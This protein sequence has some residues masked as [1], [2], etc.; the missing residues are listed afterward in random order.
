MG[1]P[2]ITLVLILF[3]GLLSLAGTLP[4]NTT[5]PVP[6]SLTESI[7]PRGLPLRP[8]PQPEVLCEAVQPDGTI[9]WSGFLSHRIAPDLQGYAGP[10]E[11][12]VGIDPEGRVAGLR[13]LRHT[14]TP[15]F[16]AGIDEP[17]FLDQFKGKNLAD[18]L[19]PGE[20]L[21]GI[22]QATVTVE[23]ICEGIR[24]C[25]RFAA[26]PRNPDGTRTAVP[27]SGKA[28]SPDRS[29]AWRPW[30][31]LVGTLV[32]FITGPLLPRRLADLLH[33]LLI[34]FIGTLFLSLTHL[35]MLFRS[36]SSLLRL[37]VYWL[38][39]FAAA[40]LLLLWKHRG[41]CRFLCPCGRLQDA[42]AASPSRSES[43]D[44]PPEGLPQAEGLPR[45]LGRT[46]LWCGLIAIALIPAFPLERLEL[47]APL[48]LLR[49]D[50][51][52]L[53]FVIAA[54]VG[55][56]LNHRFYCRTLCPLDALFTDLE[57]LR[58][59]SRE[60]ASPSSPTTPENLS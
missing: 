51:F 1:K 38:V 13:I 32:L 46:L 53:L 60:N 57:H 43:G 36:P 6:A 45:G 3:T 22:T 33:A 8:G 47:F 7:A 34:G 42:L 26:L 11:L 41:Y 12:L 4:Q 54:A 2:L 58:P 48:F 55:S 9:V 23:A 19:K 14:E 5:H 24:R 35:G 20:D 40:L 39:F 59:R 37:P 56:L 52:A 30:A 31:A 50:A 10:I 15:T 44:P 27:D 18:T 49:S 28:A 16:V 17:W 21:D 29:R 25:L